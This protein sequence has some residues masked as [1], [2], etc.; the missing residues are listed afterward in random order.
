[1][2]VSER[3][4]KTLNVVDILTSYSLRIEKMFDFLI[5]WVLINALIREKAILSKKSVNETNDAQ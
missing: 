3:I 2:M 4:I 1:M 5:V